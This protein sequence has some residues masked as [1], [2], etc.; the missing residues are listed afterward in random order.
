[1]HGP[2]RSLLLLPF[3]QGSHSR[4]AI[5]E[6]YKQPLTTALTKLK[7]PDHSATLVIAVVGSFLRPPRGRAPAGF[8]WPYTQSVLAGFYSLA[9]YICAQQSVITDTDGGPNSVDTQVMLIHDDHPPVSA[10]GDGFNGTV[11][12]NFSDFARQQST[13]HSI[14]H[15]KSPDGLLLAGLYADHVKGGPNPGQNIIGL[16]CDTAAQHQ[17]NTQL[18]QER[19]ASPSRQY[20]V[21]CLGG[22]FDHLHPGHKLLLAAGA[23]LLNVPENHESPSRFVIGV[24]GDEMLKNKKF[25]E[26]VQPWDVRARGVL[27][28]L[29][30]FID[31]PMHAG[32]ALTSQREGQLVGTF[33][34]GRVVVECVVFQDLYGP[35]ITI[36]DMDAL[37]VSGETRSGG[38]A[39]NEK[40]KEQGWKELN[41]YEV[42]VL[43][44]RGIIDED[45]EQAEDFGAKI[46][47]TAIRQQ[48]AEAG[49]P[50]GRL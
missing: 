49:S 9:A 27:N 19:P 4:R 12:R 46:S 40:R 37:V 50:G 17:R 20:K 43:D 24:T 31:H 38:K 33:R 8:S 3:A 16:D 47:S 11:V 35:T 18:P 32:P 26:Y 6:L 28:Y 14:F 7:S 36:E 44:A 29:H 39:V 34:G 5:A 48:K 13:W 45:V 21:V 15:M 30:S 22:T 1:M 23:L 42:D 10:Y 25:A 41:V 2:R